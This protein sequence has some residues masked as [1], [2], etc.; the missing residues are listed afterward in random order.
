MRRALVMACSATKRTASCP[1]PALQLYD[2]PI[3]RTLRTR[4]GELPAARQARAT[5]DLVILVL[6]AEHGFLEVGTG[7]A[8]YDRRMTAARAAELIDHPTAAFARAELR[9][10]DV[11]V[12]A[13][14]RHYA[15]AVQAVAPFLPLGA[16]LAGEGI[17]YQRAAL[18]GWM[19]AC[20]EPAPGGSPAMEE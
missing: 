1:L 13:G 11:T 3:W 2:G 10:A 17:G 7:L 9:R 14:G 12:V 16:Y 5:G 19:R 4:L 20:F 15:A 18:S 6:S 8:D